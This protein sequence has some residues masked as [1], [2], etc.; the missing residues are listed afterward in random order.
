MR[1]KETKAFLSVGLLVFVAVFFSHQ[2]VFAPPGRIVARPSSGFLPAILDVLLLG[3]VL[4]CLFSSLKVKSFLK[5]G[6][7]KA[8]FLLFSFAFAILFVAQLVSLSVSSGLLD[9][10][11][12]IVSLIRLLSI[13]SLASGIYSIKKVLS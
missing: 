4:L 9:I 3:G 8:G 10:S 7:L 12:T 13:I 1:K 11:L 2:E 5:E 6:E